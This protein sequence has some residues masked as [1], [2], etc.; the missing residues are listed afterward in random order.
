MAHDGSKVRVKR[1]RGGVEQCG[2]DIPLPR[3]RSSK[4]AC[5]SCR[6]LLFKIRHP[7]TA[8]N[9]ASWFRAC[10]KISSTLATR[11]CPKATTTNSTLYLLAVFGGLQEQFV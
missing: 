3:R 6:T 5:R 1:L 11:L 2:E 10:A 7:L 4:E 8:A 9:R